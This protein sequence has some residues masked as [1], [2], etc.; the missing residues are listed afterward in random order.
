MLPLHKGTKKTN[1]Y[2]QRKLDWWQVMIS[3][4]QV[5]E[6]VFIGIPLYELGFFNKMKLIFLDMYNAEETSIL[7]KL[8]LP[9]S[10]LQSQCMVI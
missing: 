5:S 3:Q 9:L 2:L 4:Q 6:Q 10:A 1:Y 7:L 8:D